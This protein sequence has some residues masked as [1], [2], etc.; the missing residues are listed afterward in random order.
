MP[1]FK[2][3]TPMTPNV[4]VVIDPAIASAVVTPKDPN[5]ATQVDA[6]KVI[7]DLISSGAVTVGPVHLILDTVDDFDSDTKPRA[8]GA[9]PLLI[10]FTQIMNLKNSLGVMQDL[11]VPFSELAGELVELLDNSGPNEKW[12]LSATSNGDGTYTGDV[13]R[14]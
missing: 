2:K 3:K 9:L 12:V 8:A 1:L 4:Q 5:F 11:S 10:Q 7:N 6:V 14:R 13:E